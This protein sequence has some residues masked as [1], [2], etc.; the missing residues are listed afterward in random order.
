[1]QKPVSVCLPKLRQAARMLE[2]E[3]LLRMKLSLNVK[4]F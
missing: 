1:M 4:F 2:F 3:E